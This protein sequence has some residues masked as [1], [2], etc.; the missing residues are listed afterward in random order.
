MTHPLTCVFVKI[1]LV[2]TLFCVIPV[3]S[4]PFAFSLSLISTISSLFSI[5]VFSFRTSRP[6]DVP[7]VGVEPGEAR[8]QYHEIHP[9]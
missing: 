5:S 9:Q 4:I 8:Q 2:R 6:N 7:E 1:W 3:I